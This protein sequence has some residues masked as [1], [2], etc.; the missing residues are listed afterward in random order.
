MPTCSAASTSWPRKPT[1]FMPVHAKKSERSSTRRPWKR[2]SSLTALPVR[3][4][5]LREV[6]ATPIS[7]PATKFCLPKW[8]IIRISCLGSNWPSVREPCCV[9][10]RL[11][12][13]GLLRLDTLDQLLTKRTKLVA[14]T[15]LSNVLGTI[16]PMA[17]IIRRAHEVGAVV[18]VDG[19]QSVPHQKTDVAELDCDFLAFSGHKMLGPSGIGVLYGKRELLES[20][21]PFLGGGGMIRHVELDRFLARR[22]AAK[23]RGRHPAHRVGHCLGRCDRLSQRHRHGC[24][25]S[26]RSPINPPGA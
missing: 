11:T 25:P 22:S 19:A 21:P 17:E 14:V 4:T 13:D 18:L 26:A 1:T 15:A 24:H 8:S 12:D 20:M 3:S 16:N 5:L 2:L 23:I 6:G 9:T 10:S 7:A